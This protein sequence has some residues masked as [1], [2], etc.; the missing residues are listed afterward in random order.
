MELTPKE[1]IAIDPAYWVT[2]Y[3]VM[4][5][6]GPFSITGHEY[7]LEPMQSIHKRVCYMKA[8]GGGFS[9]LEILRTIHGLIHGKYPQGALYLFPSA[10]DV[11]DFSK[12][13]FGP[14]IAANKES[15]GRYVKQ[16]GTKTDTA[17]IKR[18]GNSFLYLRGARLSQNMED[19]S[20]E[21]ES[22][23]LRG[24]QVDRVVFDEFGLMDELAMEKAKGRMGHSKVKEESYITNPG[25]PGD[26]ADKW[27][28]LS[29]QREWGRRC[30]C[31]Q[32]TIA[33]DEFPDCVGIA[34]GGRGFIKC[35][36]CGK[37]VPFWQGRGTG[38]WVSKAPANTS[39]MAGYH[40]SHLT[41][42]YNDPADVLGDF[43]NPPHGNQS[44][45]IRLR[46]GRSHV[47]AD[48]QLTPMTVRECHGGDYMPSRHNGPCAMGVDVGKT[49][50]VVIGTRVG[51]DSYELLK[52]ARVANWEDIHALAQ[53][54]GVKS[55]VIDI[56]PY[57]DS[58]RRFQ[59]SEPYRIYLC[60]YTDNPMHDAIWDDITHTVK[61][62]RTGA[63][64]ATHKLF[65]EKRIRLPRP[66]EEMSV[67]VEQACE[68]AKVQEMDKRTN[69]PLYR[70]RGS[71]DHYRNALNY[72][73]L[74]ASGHRVACIN[75]AN[76]QL[77]EYAIHEFKVA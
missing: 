57:E 10:E 6:A 33:D 21:K 8:T 64:D 30:G 32:W 55:A 13:R 5:S 34:P 49:F 3:K 29:D 44:D 35:K 4:L 31:G 11:S 48:D 16:A 53:R 76:Y 69:Q 25:R 62:Y 20:T 63:F 61:A 28:R 43:M 74:A 7:Q 46:L 65:T 36:K 71:N 56:R 77:Q 18:I 59:A 12:A 14:L 9:E 27:Y 41:S 45:V 60:Q 70:Y 19:G 22:S 40:W 24:I 52:A 50:H 38:Q 72:F 1:L 39:F 26:P 66:S 47:A 42:L 51:K 37:A 58:A 54:Y 17:S 23:K 73:Y 15:I 68:P 67:F 2:F 75:S